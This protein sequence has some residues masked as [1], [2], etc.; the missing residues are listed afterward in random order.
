MK[1]VFLIAFLLLGGATFAQS[2][3][4]AEGNTLTVKEIPPVWPGCEESESPQKAC[5]KQK[6]VEHLKNNYKY[7][8]NEEGKI[9][10]GKAV[11][12]FNIDAEGK[13]EILKAEGDQEALRE[14]AKRIIKAIPKMTPGQ[15]GGKPVAIRYKV[16]FT[17]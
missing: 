10:R 1:K 17:F 7:P 11:I 15:R 16:P 13:V 9:I 12:T 3:V 5:F 4:K 6:L 8:R 2:G 14:E